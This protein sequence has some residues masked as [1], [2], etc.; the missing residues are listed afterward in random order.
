A[1]PGKIIQCMR[2]ATS[3]NPVMLLDEV[4]K[5]STD[6]RGDPS[7]ALLEVLDPEQN[8]NFNDHYLDCDYDLSKV[9]FITTAN[10]LDRIPRPLQDRMEIIRVPGYTET[11]KLQIAK[12]YLVKKQ[13][14]ANGLKEENIEF[15]DKALLG[16]IRH[17]T[18]EA[19]VRNLER[20]IASICR[21]VAVEVVK[22]DRNAH[23]K[24]SLASLAKHLGP[25]KFRF[26]IAETEPQIGVATGLAWTELGG[27]L[28]GVEVT[29]VPGRGKLTVT[30]QLGE[31]M[32]ESAQAALSYVRSRSEQLGL[33]SNFYQKIDIHIH[34]PEGAIPKDGPSA[35]ITLATALV[36][37]LCRVPVKNDLAM[38]G[39]ITLR[40]RVLPIGGL[41]EKAMA[42][43]RGGI[44]TILMPRDN[45]KD[46]P[47]IP[48]QVLKGLALI[49]V[50]HM[51]DVLKRALVLVDPEAFL[52]PTLG[53]AAP[54]YLLED[55]DKDE[56]SVDE[57]DEDVA[58]PHPPNLS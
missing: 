55:N 8:C 34:L 4:D 40:G 45:A 20:E 9:L 49:E 17:Y 19:G 29:I 7:S 15:S 1:L 43:H 57:D 36:S 46:V 18:R 22:S 13:R 25:P 47:E 2:K 14:E 6:F 3:G 31:V 37:A 52:K 44:K 53:A 21:K 24:I 16:V 28:L 5:M 30:G 42:A 11:E 23:V 12:K 39:E 32:Q 35:G 10:T 54:L 58:P 26:G 41:K 51:D 48:A 38:T 56:S 33:K 27:E 50:D